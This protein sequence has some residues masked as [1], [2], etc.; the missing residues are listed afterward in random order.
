MI[1]RSG[2]WEGI[3]NA[4]SFM[5]RAYHRPSG[6]RETEEGW[7]CSYT[8]WMAKTGITRGAADAM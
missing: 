2:G 7:R 4:P 1:E 3:M 8:R 5:A 6:L